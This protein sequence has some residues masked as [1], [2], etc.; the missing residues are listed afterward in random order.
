MTRGIE[1]RLWDRPSSFDTSF[2]PFF[3][4]FRRTFG[5]ASRGVKTSRGSGKDYEK[6]QFPERRIEGGIKG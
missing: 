2:S 3:S 4:L 1:A 5:I 6:F